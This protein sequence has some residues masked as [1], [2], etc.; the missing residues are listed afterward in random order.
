LLKD[1]AVAVSSSKDILEMLGFEIAPRSTL[2]LFAEDRLS[3]NEKKI[4]ETIG[5][6]IQKDELIYRLDLPVGYINSILVEMEM[7]GII[8]EKDG[9][10]FAHSLN[11]M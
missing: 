9:V 10:I 7:K 8:K 2:N 6:S 3:E 11:Y 1:G 4:L 5:A